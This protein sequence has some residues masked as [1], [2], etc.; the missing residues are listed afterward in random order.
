MNRRQFLWG[1]AA[2]LA[3]A[4]GC[5]QLVP[6]RE[7]GTA[8]APA[9]PARTSVDEDPRPFRVALL[10]DPHT[11]AADSDLAGAINGKLADALEDY[12]SLRPDLW[13]VNGDITDRGQME[14]YSAFKKVMA[15]VAKAD[16]L[17]LNTGNHDFYDPDATDEEEVGRFREAFGLQTAYSSRVAGGLHFVMLASEQ[18]K[19]AKGPPEWAWLSPEQLTWF[20]QV[21]AAHSDKLTVVGLHQPLQETVIWSHGGNDFGGCGQAAELRA[22]LERNPQVKLWL[23]GHTHMGA[24]VPGSA[25]QLNGIWFVTLGST[26]YQFV[27]STAPEAAEYGGF[28]RDLSASQSRMLEVWPDRLVLRARD[29]IQKSWMDEFELTIPRS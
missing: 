1:T 29:H 24:E 6:N 22:I 15:K 18:R 16:Q 17:L 19:T 20:D 10:S 7:Q 25:T 14:Q 11:V 26:F 23:S 2:V 4:T 9:D 28:V 3:A 27:Q 21:L 8:E 12:A 13:L 5:T